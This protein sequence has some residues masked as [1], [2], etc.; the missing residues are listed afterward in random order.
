MARHTSGD[1]DAPTY[2]SALD[3][4]RALS[5]REMC[6]LLGIATIT[7]AQW[8]PRGEGPRFFR[9]GNRGIRYRLGDV[10]AYRNARS[11]GGAK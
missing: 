7:A 1:D 5:T 11:V 2:N 9:V 3:L 8:R 4:E 10:L 6:G